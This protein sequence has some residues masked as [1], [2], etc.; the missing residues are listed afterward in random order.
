MF[1]MSYV[2]IKVSEGKIVHRCVISGEFINVKHAMALLR[3]WTVEPTDHAYGWI[4][5]PAKQS[6]KATEQVSHINSFTQFAE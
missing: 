4:Y 6:E 1:E 5:Y 3:L 2:R